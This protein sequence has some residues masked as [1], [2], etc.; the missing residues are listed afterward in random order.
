MKRLIYRLFPKKL[1]KMIKQKF[2]VTV[3]KTTPNYILDTEDKPMR[4]KNAVVT[5]GNGAIGGAVCMLLA[6]KGANVY[7]SGRNGG[8]VEKTVGKM[9]NMGLS[10]Y[11]MVMNVSDENSIESVFKETF[12]DKS[13]DI[14]VCCAGGGSRENMSSLTEQRV[15]IIDEILNV[16]L[17]GTMLCTK[18]ALKKMINQNSG[19]IVI[20]SSAVGIQGK[21]NYSEYAAA[22]AGLL[23]FVKSMALETGKNNIN[24]NC[25]TPGFI[26]RSDYD[27]QS[28]KW[29]CASNCLNKV[30]TLEDI[31][32][33]VCFLA[34]D[35]AGFITG[36]NLVVDGGRTL[37]LYGDR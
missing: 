33:A 16:N 29:L 6:A 24:I 19:K 22:K 14:L 37:G 9:R 31:A 2:T 15:D 10:A 30:G 34:S 1:K 32:E 18:G 4:G 35:K 13:L 8:K 11:P 28:K 23:G 27:E 12:A 36:Q 5:G 20:L 17:R 7:V 26:Q 21:A 25:V 3:Y